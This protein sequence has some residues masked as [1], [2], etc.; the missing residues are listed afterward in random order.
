MLHRTHHDQLFGERLLHLPDATQTTVWFELEGPELVV[1]TEILR[2][3]IEIAKE[4][5]DTALS[6]RYAT[7]CVHFKPL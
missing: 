4:S 1:Y 3:F 2:Y 6:L 7:T 5:D